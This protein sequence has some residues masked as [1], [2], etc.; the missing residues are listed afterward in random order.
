MK[1]GAL[2]GCC[3]GSAT[4]GS[5]L[6]SKLLCM[7]GALQIRNG[8]I[9]W[10]CWKSSSLTGYSSSFSLPQL[11]LPIPRAWQGFSCRH[12]GDPVTHTS[13]GPTGELTRCNYL[14]FSKGRERLIWQIIPVV[15]SLASAE[16]SMILGLFFPSRKDLLGAPWEVEPLPSWCKT[17]MLSNE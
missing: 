5:S 8:V 16:A 10:C 6:L 15:G 9:S 13:T 4:M 17:G 12:W 14:C 1:K 3:C 7:L 11:V 2:S